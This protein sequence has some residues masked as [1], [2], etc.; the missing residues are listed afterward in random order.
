M[1]S[2]DVDS[3]GQLKN[4]DHWSQHTSTLQLE[5]DQEV[6]RQGASR[7][8]ISAHRSRTVAPWRLGL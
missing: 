4:C 3:A 6:L 1:V 5:A 7:G 8:A 2:L